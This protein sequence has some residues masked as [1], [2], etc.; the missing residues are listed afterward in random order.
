VARQGKEKK[1]STSSPID[2]LSR[3]STFTFVGTV[4]ELNAAT[5]AEVPVTESTAVITVDEVLQAPPMLAGRVGT[6]ITVQL[7]DA[8]QIREGQQ[9]TFFTNGWIYGED[10]AVQ[11]V[12][13]VERR[14]DD[15]QA[16]EL[17]TLSPDT[18][19][20]RTLRLRQ[21]L[22]EAEVVVLGMVTEIKFPEGYDTHGLVS[23][24]AP[25][26][27]EATIQIQT[28]YKGDL[29]ADQD[30]VKVIYSRSEDIRWH[31]TPILDVGQKGIFVLNKREIPELQREEYAALDRLDYQL[32]GQRD[33]IQTLLQDS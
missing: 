6:D 14:V 23:E 3:Q 24:H 7:S 22:A 33:L 10:I 2:D 31:R 27:R 26:W 1:V 18:R 12:G 19:E 15:E 21:R 32:P 17:S 16:A 20:N 25:L 13:H 9:A 4:K 29:P 28:V 5:M 30:T 11:E 8:Q